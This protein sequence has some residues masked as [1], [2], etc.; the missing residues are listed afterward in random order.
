MLSSYPV[1]CPH[2]NCGWSGTLIPSHVRGGED[3]EI[4]SMDRG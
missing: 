1:V 3:A 4:A 2:G